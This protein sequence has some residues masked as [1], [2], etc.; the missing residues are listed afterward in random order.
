MIR[1]AKV[2]NKSS[3]DVDCFFVYR[4]LLFNVN[5]LIFIYFLVKSTSLVVFFVFNTSPFLPSG[6]SYPLDS[7]PFF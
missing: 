2:D 5:F 7:E 6:H 3:F 4:F 1:R